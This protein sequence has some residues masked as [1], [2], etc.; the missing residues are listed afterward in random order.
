MNIREKF[1]NEVARMLI[2][3]DRQELILPSFFIAQACHESN[4]GTSELAFNAKNL[5]GVKGKGYTINTD[6]F[7]KGKWIVVSAEF[8]AY[9]SMQDSVRDQ[10][11]RFTERERYKGLIGLRDYKKACNEVYRSGYATDPKYPQK[12]I[13]LIEI[14]KLYEYDRKENT[15][16]IMG[17]PPVLVTSLD[18][19]H[20]KVKAAA[21]RFLAE[22]GKAGIPVKIT[23]TYR[24]VQTQQ[25]YYSWGRTKL[26]P[27]KRNM[28]KVTDC[29]GVQR[30]S[31]HQSGL[32]FDICINIPGKE[33]DAVLLKKAGKIGMSLGLT[34]GGSWKTIVDMPHYEIPP[35]RIDNFKIIEE[36]D[37]MAKFEVTDKELGY[38]IAAIKR[39]TELKML[40]KPDKHIENL[41]ADP[42]TW[43]LWVVQVNIAEK[44]M[45]GK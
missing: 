35:S 28:T 44:M 21:L 23:Q 9:K 2:I 40:G 13:D 19:L 18:R 39:L 38:G 3:E 31:R 36:E 30:P 34:W 37:D 29:D 8:Q 4:F 27:F 17:T 24:T 32:A 10:I 20:P 1:I 14:Y 41:Q 22:C 45:E 33:W 25:E 12:L 15:N 42:T 6:E 5:F 26:N 43:A 16:M 7:I 11:K